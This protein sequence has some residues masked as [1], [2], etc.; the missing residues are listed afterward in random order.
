[1]P[2]LVIELFTNLVKNGNDTKRTAQEMGITKG[3]SLIKRKIA[4]D[5]IVKL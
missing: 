4:T 1:M 3:K 2:E 5:C